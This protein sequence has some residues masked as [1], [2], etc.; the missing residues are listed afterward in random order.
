[1]PYFDSLKTNRERLGIRIA[2]LAK[3]A[4]VDRST[5]SRI[6]KHHNSTPETLHAI[7]NALNELGANG[8]L[9]YEDVVSDISKF[10]GR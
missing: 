7:I 4:G 1:M 9:S 3:A 10:G 6:E 8:R 2:A 5:V